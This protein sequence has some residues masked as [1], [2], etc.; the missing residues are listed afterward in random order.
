MH[1]A[2]P[3]FHHASS[4]NGA[5]AQGPVSESVL[6]VEMFKVYKFQFKFCS[7]VIHRN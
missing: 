4:W 1:G 5:Y 3:L 2:V 7:I 6:D